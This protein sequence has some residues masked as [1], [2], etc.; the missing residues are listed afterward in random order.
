MDKIKENN[1][2]Y[3]NKDV[4]KSSKI[5]FSKKKKITFFKL[6]F[7]YYRVYMVQTL[8]LMIFIALSSVCAVIIPKLTQ[9][10]I[11]KAMEDSTSMDEIISFSSIIISIFIIRAIFMFTNMLISGKLGK[12]IEI[13]LRNKL[14]SNLVEL[15]MSFYSDKKIGEILTKLIS[16][17]EI[18]GVQS[19]NIP[20]SI[21]SAIFTSIGA[22]IILFTINIKLTL[23]SIALCLFM[24]VTLSFIFGILRKTIFKTRSTMTNI[25]GDVTNRIQ[26]INLIKSF[27]T[28]RYE[29]NR[30]I[31]LHKTY[32]SASLPQVRSQALLVSFLIVFLSSINILVLVF[33]II[34]LKN[35]SLTFGH[36][37]LT[38]SEGMS[39]IIA[40][41][42]GV[43]TLVFPVMALSRTFTLLAQASTAATR[44]SEL[45][46]EESLIDPNLNVEPIKA[47]DGNIL[48]K[49]ITFKYPK[50]EAIIFKDFTF[51]FEKGRS[52]AFVGETGVGKST[53]SK[54][55]LRFYDPTSGTIYINNSEN[56]ENN[57]K[58]LNLPEFLK[59]TGYVEQEPSIIAGTIN[60]NIKYGTFDAK[61]DEII[62]AAKKAELHKYINSLP[63]KYETVLG[64]NGLTLSGGQKQ[65]MVIAR[66]FLKNPEIL[67]LDEATSALDNI[68]EKQIQKNLDK[69]MENRTTFVIAHRLSTIQNVDYILVLEKDKGIV[70]IGNFKELIKTPGHFKDL[71]EAGLMK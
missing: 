23:I 47:I 9:K 50:T 44:V 55:I 58:N 37:S 22:I 18:I 7:I 20:Q 57:L 63:N 52:Y 30:F 64:E 35:D 70:Q 24:L 26:N 13:D 39:I 51:T 12:K 10:L 60:D 32:Y 61:S 41:M 49:K 28:E 5:K 66:M 59:F 6:I 27:G 11:N 34:L 67:I 46:V 43:N 53:I 54:L 16:D 19:Q 21:L 42:T 71:Y 8:T 65:R 69:L 38:Y 15:D 17:T 40:T 14:L 2:N 29:K 33:G 25:N 1:N 36:S 68:I 56:K 45:I 62:E 3:N 48:F 31:N 4:L